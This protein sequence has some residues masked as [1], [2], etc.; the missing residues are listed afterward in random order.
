MP[1]KMI[2]FLIEILDFDTA[3]SLN[4]KLFMDT[5]F[6]PTAWR[7]GERMSAM[8]ISACAELSQQCEPCQ[9]VQCQHVLSFRE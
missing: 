3:P 9:H 8:C 5:L 7:E 6:L 4:L 1:K 2:L